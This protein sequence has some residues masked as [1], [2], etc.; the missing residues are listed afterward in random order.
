MDLPDQVDDKAHNF[1]ELL[2]QCVQ[3]RCKMISER[4]MKGLSGKG[5]L[6][7]ES[8]CLR[9]RPLRKPFYFLKLQFKFH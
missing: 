7:L 2:V 5:M 8:F 6:Q 3:S 9:D 4:L 1:L